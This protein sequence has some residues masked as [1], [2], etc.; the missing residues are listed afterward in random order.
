MHI[1]PTH[2]YTIEIGFLH[3]Q[4]LFSPRT[5]FQQSLATCC[6]IFSRILRHLVTSRKRSRHI[7]TYPNFFLPQSTL[8]LLIGRG[9]YNNRTCRYKWIRCNMPQ[10]ATIRQFRQIIKTTLYIQTIPTIPTLFEKGGGTA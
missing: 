4:F 9:P 10:Y 6:L 8:C 7:E 5:Y 3:F 2:K 1:Q